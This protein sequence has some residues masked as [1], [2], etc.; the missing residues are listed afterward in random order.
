MFLF[1]LSPTVMY[2]VIFL[3]SLSY[4]CY[5]FS[6]TLFVLLSVQQFVKLYVELSPL[7]SVFSLSASTHSNV[8][9][10]FVLSLSYCVSKRG[11]AATFQLHRGPKIG[12]GTSEMGDDSDASAWTFL[13]TFIIFSVS[14][15]SSFGEKR[16]FGLIAF[17][18]FI[19]FLRKKKNFFENIFFWTQKK[20]NIL[21][22]SIFFI[23]MKNQL[24]FFH[25]LI[26]KFSA[27]IWSWR[28]VFLGSYFI[29]LPIIPMIL[30][31][32]TPLISL[33]ASLISLIASLI[34]LI[35]NLISREC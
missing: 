27:Q 2:R 11:Y 34:S 10:Q 22:F 21:T 20:K 13:K 1:V 18:P 32:F 12:G 23:S 33:I 25:F 17:S 19:C 35:T 7:F 14:F 24:I 26:R 15:C 8:S 31:K 6:F 16:I 28:P 3:Y 4:V 30:A 5:F 9:F 29:V